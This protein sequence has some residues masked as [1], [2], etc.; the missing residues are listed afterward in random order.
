MK[1]KISNSADIF[2]NE[3]GQTGQF[4][5]WAHRHENV[6]PGFLIYHIYKPSQKY[7]LNRSRL[8]KS[9]NKNKKIR[10]GGDIKM[11]MT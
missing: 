11:N 2:Q 8:L 10:P 1:T 9:L 3:L 7:S 6:F 5:D 4:A